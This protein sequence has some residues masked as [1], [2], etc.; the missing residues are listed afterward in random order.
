MYRLPH[1][2]VW[3]C[4]AVAGIFGQTVLKERNDGYVPCIDEQLDFR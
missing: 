2:P 3:E 4:E 1:V